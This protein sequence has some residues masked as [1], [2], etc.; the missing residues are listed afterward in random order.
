MKNI[1]LFLFIFT[2]A[3]SISAQDN[4]SSI[5]QTKIDYQQNPCRLDFIEAYL[6]LIDKEKKEE[7]QKVKFDYVNCLENSQDFSSKQVGFLLKNL[8]SSKNDTTYTFYVKNKPKFEKNY[9]DSLLVW[10]SSLEEMFFI[11]ETDSLIQSIGEREKLTQQEIEEFEKIVKRYTDFSKKLRKESKEKSFHQPKKSGVVDYLIY[12]TAIQFYDKHKELDKFGSYLI[13]YN[14]VEKIESYKKDIFGK[15][16]IPLRSF[17]LYTAYYLEQKD[18]KI[19]VIKE[20]SSIW[21]G[22]ISRGYI[23]S[24]VDNITATKVFYY[25]KEKQEAQKMLQRVFK[26]KKS[27]FEEQQYKY[28]ETQINQL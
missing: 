10:E 28:L 24:C 11:Q 25:N 12:T 8:V 7:I 4:N 6:N 16:N 3:F 5:E 2:I 1:F 22:L 27:N 9:G 23:T 19:E 20:L 26:L 21:K 15:V 17:A 13:R 14:Q 18:K